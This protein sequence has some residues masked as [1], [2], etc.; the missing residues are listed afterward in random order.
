[1]S[2]YNEISNEGSGMKKEG[3][4][5]GRKEGRKEGREKERGEGRQNFNYCEEQILIPFPPS[6]TVYSPQVEM[7]SCSS[8][9]S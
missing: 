2:S 1:M 8:P 9:T 6:V 5:K 4:L 3:K 7:I